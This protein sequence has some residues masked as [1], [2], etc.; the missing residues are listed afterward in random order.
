MSDLNQL[1]LMEKIAMLEKNFADG[2]ASA[3]QEIRNWREQASEIIRRK[4]YADLDVS[5][6]IAQKL[7]GLITEMNKRLMNEKEMTE[8]QR[9][10]IFERK[11]ATAYFLSFFDTDFDQILKGIKS[12]VDYELG[13]QEK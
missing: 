6:L 8:L 1:E 7:R 10:R 12:A 3:L 9:A 4:D 11:E 5:K 2:D 13:S